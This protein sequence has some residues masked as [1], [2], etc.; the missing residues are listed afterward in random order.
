[1]GRTGKERWGVSQRKV[2]LRIHVEDVRADMRVYADTHTIC[3]FLWTLVHVCRQRCHTHLSR[4][5]RFSPNGTIGTQDISILKGDISQS[6]PRSTVQPNHDDSLTAT[7]AGRPGAEKDRLRS[8][9]TMG[10]WESGC[11]IWDRK[12][13]S[14]YNRNPSTGWWLCSLW[15]M[16]V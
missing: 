14:T 16:A 2:L 11:W 12:H 10:I 5:V 3:T 8:E 6:E 13:L 4:R 7:W 15:C 1:M 9:K